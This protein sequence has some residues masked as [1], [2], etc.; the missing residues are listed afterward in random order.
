MSNFAHFFLILPNFAHFL[1]ICI[2]EGTRSGI[3]RCLDLIQEKLPAHQH[4]DLSLKQINEPSPAD[5]LQTQARQGL[6]VTLPPGQM[7]GAVITAIVSTA[8]IFIQL[9]ENPTFAHL[10]RLE[11]YMFNVYEKSH[12]TP[13]VPS[14][15]VEPGLVC[16]T[17]NQEKYYR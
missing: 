8:H 9:P 4:P 15:A 14:E 3:E 12:R 1:Q 16:V 17:K 2:I 5:L 11:R 6:L 10:E 7:S 13:K